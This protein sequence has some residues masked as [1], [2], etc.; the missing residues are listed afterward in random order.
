MKPGQT[1]IP[2]DFTDASLMS[3]RELARSLRASLREDV[4]ALHSEQRAPGALR[5]LLVGEKQDSVLYVQSLVRWFTSIGLECSLQTLPNDA[6]PQTVQDALR[7]ASDDPAVTGLLVQMPLPAHLDYH[8]VF[9]AMAPLK[10]V[11]GLHPENI[12]LLASGKPRFVPSTPLAGMALLDL[13]EIA[14]EGKHVA[15]LGR[16]N[17]VGKPLAQLVL[18]RNA[19]VTLLHSRSRNIPE[20]VR[21]ADVVAAAVGV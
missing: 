20:S 17:V 9:D 6:S 1:E 18:A 7:R 3:G 21:M 19:T 14:L 5:I 15:I 8:D 13:H 10:D 4:V 12:G 2:Q 11:E 16:S